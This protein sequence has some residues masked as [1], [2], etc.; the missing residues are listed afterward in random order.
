MNQI[1]IIRP[2]DDEAIYPPPEIR[3]IY[4]AKAL[5]W[6]YFSIVIIWWI[7]ITIGVLLILTFIEVISASNDP[8]LEPM[9]SIIHDI[10]LSTPIIYAVVV[11]LPSLLLVPLY[12]KS[13]EFIVHGDEIVVKK[14]LINKTVKFCPFRTITNISTRAGP[15]DRLFGIGNVQVET[16]G[17]SGQ[18]TSPE[19]KLEGLLLY[20][21]IRDYI[22]SRLNIYNQEGGSY[23]ASY[24][25]IL[26]SSILSELREIKE[27]LKRKKRY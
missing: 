16:A 18:S 26:E 25:D 24:Q 20:N 14:G 21:E 10:I 13:M 17:K 12:V 7:L 22:L 1:T 4:P 23:G 3:K 2:R 5:I 6:K 27:I 8:N 11:F 19:E 9:P 15:L